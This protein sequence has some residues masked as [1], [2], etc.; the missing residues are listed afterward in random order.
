MAKCNE[1]NILAFQKIT[2]QNLIPTVDFWHSIGYKHIIFGIIISLLILYFFIP[3]FN[4]IRDIKLLKTVTSRKRGTK[5]ERDLV[6]KLLKHGIP[7]QT[8]F[9]DLYVEY[10]GKT[11]QI[12]IVLATTQGIIVIE[13]KDYNGW[14]FGNGNYS[15]WTQVF[16]YEKFQFYNPIKQN[17]SHIK[18]L[19]KQ[20]EQFREI[21]FFSIIVFYGNCE[22]KEINFVP[23]GT[24]LVKPHR[25]FEVLK[26][27]KENFP[28]APYTNKIEVVNTL[29]QA[30]LNGENSTY[31]KKHIENINDM[32]GKNRI[33]D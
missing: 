28:R 7:A 26:L 29:K 23:H 18:A 10:N 4:K 16:P 15:Y 13:V 31:Q 14:I 5:T 21:P 20:C 27:I 3:I 33:F 19:K 6:L 25:I 32:L 1:F 9:H 24:Y 11:S 22:L 17:L 12:D 8:I 30:V 2:N